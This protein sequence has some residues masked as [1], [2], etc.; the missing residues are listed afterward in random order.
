MKWYNQIS[1]DGQGLFR[2]RFFAVME[3]KILP[4]NI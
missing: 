2:L 4:K 1:A 3:Q